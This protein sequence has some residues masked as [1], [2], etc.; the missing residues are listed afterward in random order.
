MSLVDFLTPLSLTCYMPQFASKGFS[1]VEQLA[2]L[3]G[4]EL[5]SVLVSLGVLKGH[6]TKL[7]KALDDR[8]RTDPGPVKKQHVE[9]PLQTISQSVLRSYTPK[10]TLSQ[11]QVLSID[12]KK[13]MDQ[14]L[15]KL[16]EIEQTRDDVMKAKELILGVDLA[17]YRKALEQIE[18]IQQTMLTMWEDC[19]ELRDK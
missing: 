18:L 16:S 19:G 5:E 14:L 17:R 3:P 8:K 2:A 6:C 12:P 4:Y 7:M 13:D 1:E 11:S 10:S 9:I 15:S